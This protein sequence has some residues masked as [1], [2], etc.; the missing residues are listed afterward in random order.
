MQLY[1]AKPLRKLQIS[2]LSFQS[3]LLT[4]SLALQ[5]IHHN[6]FFS[7]CT[8]L[9]TKNIKIF[10]ELIFGFKAILC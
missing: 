8:I 5:L 9:E 1:W 6:D 3:S 2:E 10:F 7:Y 4:S